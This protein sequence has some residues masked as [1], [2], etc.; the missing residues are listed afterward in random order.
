MKMLNKIKLPGVIYEMTT[1][2]NLKCKYCYNYWKKQEDN[3]PE[4][5]KINPKRTL[6]QF[7]KSVKCNEF[8]FSGGE[9]TINFEELLDCIMYVKAR[10][11]KVTIITNATLLDE[12]KIKLLSNLKIDLFEITVNSYD[13]E[14]HEKINGIKG[15]FDKTV[16][17]I[18][19]I[20]NRGIEVVVPIVITK[21]N[22]KD[23]NKTLDFIHNLGIK[24][25]MVNRYNIGGNGCNDI[26][27]ILPDIKNL[28]MAYARC[29]EFAMKYNL[30]LY[31][32]VCSPHCVL[33]PDDYPNIYFS[34][35]GCGELKRRYT[36]SRDGN[37]RYCNHSP[38]IIG[39][40]YQNT[41]KEIIQSDKLKKWNEIE[42]NFCQK[43]SQKEICQYGCRA[44]SQQMG[45]SLEKEDPIV[46]I[47]KIDKRL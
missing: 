23:I 43:C 35:C 18:K 32:L 29:Q 13:R 37:I 30:T 12:Q 42:P 7:M 31:S 19:R 41:M 34:N 4:I 3:I 40:I 45:Y 36:L 8:T 38:E 9:P 16:E 26:N 39:N 5:E 27:S 47:Y 6:K 46:S 24:R 17:N 44:A 20:Q 11:K 33:N 21:Y 22:T 14:I 2:C 10:N 28:R 15:S 25:I 1:L